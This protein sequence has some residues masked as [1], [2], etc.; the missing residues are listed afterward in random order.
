MMM[1]NDITSKIETSFL[2]IML[3]LNKMRMDRMKPK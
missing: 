2:V 3:V 1:I